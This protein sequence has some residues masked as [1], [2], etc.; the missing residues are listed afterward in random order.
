[1]RANIIIF[2]VFSD[3]YLSGRLCKKKIFTSVEN[4]LALESFHGKTAKKQLKWHHGSEIY[5]ICIFCDSRH[6]SKKKIL[7]EHISK[8]YLKNPRAILN[9][10]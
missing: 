3:L 1:M 10:S 5:R 8:I 4:A 9:F 2:F 6:N 7:V